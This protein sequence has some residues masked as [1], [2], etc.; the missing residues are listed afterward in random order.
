MVSP[1]TLP[2]SPATP[3]PQAWPSTPGAALPPGVAVQWREAGGV[4]FRFLQG[5]G[6][7]RP[8]LF[9]HGWPTWAEVWLPLIQRMDLK[10]PWVA[11]DL[12][13]Q[14]ESSLV[15]KSQRNLSGYRKALAAFV[16]AW[17]VPGFDVVGNSMGASLALMLALDRPQ[18]VSRAVVIDCAGFQRKFP[19]RTTRLYLP[20]VIPCVFRSPTP[21]SAR[22]LLR[23]AVFHDPALVTDAW[24]NAFVRAWAPRDRC[25]GY[26]DTAFALRYPDASLMDSLGAIRCP[27]LVISGRNDVQFAWKDAERTAKE[28]KGGQFAAIDSAG[29]FPM[30]EQPAQ[31]AAAVAHFLGPA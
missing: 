7:G 16:D 30:V 13:C 11:P 22:K 14:G 18:A 10:R 19:G 3:T 31:T 26:L 12:P 20:F 24:V 17:G 9:L 15:E 2:A 29:H 21:A 6:S 27:V 25:R 23:R 1:A 5:G 28:I 4:R 8:I